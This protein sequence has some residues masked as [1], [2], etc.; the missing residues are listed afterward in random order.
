MIKPKYDWKYSGVDSD[1]KYD[2][3][4]HESELIQRILYN[5]GIIGKENID[6]FMNPKKE[7]IHDPF[8]LN[9]MNTAV[10]RI[11]IAIDKSEKITI[12]G[13]Y[14]VDGITSTST[15]YK[16]LKK[17]GANVSYYIPN[18]M[19]EGY[20]INKNALEIIKKDGTSLMITVDTGI[21]AVS[22]IEYAN[23]LGLD[24][25]I[26]DHHECQ[27]VIPD[28]YAVINPKR[29]DSTYPFSMLAGVGVAFKLVHALAIRL[30]NT[31]EIWEYLDLVAIGT[32]ADIVPLVGENRIIAKFGFETISNTQN[33]GV[34]AVLTELGYKNNRITSGFIGFSIAPRLNAAGRIDDAKKCVELFITEDIEVATK[35]AKEL[36][37]NNQDRQKIEQKIFKEAIEMIEGTKEIQEANVIVLANE[38]WHHGV[39]GIVASKIVERFY[40]PT[41]LMNIE[42]GEARGSARSIS[43][44]SIFEALGKAKDYLNKFGGHEMAAGLSLEVYN[45]E[46]LRLSLVEYCEEN[47]SQDMLIPK[48]KIERK[49]GC[50]DIT[51][52][53][54]EKIDMLQPYGIGNPEPI[55]EISGE[56]IDFRLLGK[57]S[58]H[59]KLKLEQKGDI[60]DTIMF[61]SSEY[62]EKLSE[63]MEL[64]IIGTVQ[65]N[66]WNGNIYPQM[67]IKDIRDKYYNKYVQFT[68]GNCME[69]VDCDVVVTR[70]DIAGV[71]KFLKRNSGSKIKVSEIN[72]ILKTNIFKIL[73]TFDVLN[74]SNLA[75]IT[76]VD[77]II[78]FD[79]KV[80]EKVDLSKSDILKKLNALIG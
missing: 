51:P 36:E 45:V 44:F 78:E 70:E 10:N 65:N 28:A 49:I 14:D 55:F 64:D 11:I 20:G 41:I 33:I 69:M 24:V 32:I 30:S 71:Y 50:G 75:N 5:R 25:I 29:P 52:N 7:H 80:S 6:K 43:G 13:D 12:Y 37:K 40:K 18:R 56:M 61:N 73:V 8:L 58:K 38:N 57:E 2:N 74:E 79:L 23:E 63:D 67:L 62:F 72:K 1:F 17:I 15:L 4:I 77:D 59:L 68:M 53:F 60:I 39:I 22:E 46:K 31:D 66:E 42:D 47:I 48:V 54:I 9:D 3:S 34:K 16:Y 21:A 27:E 26:T 19:D 76:L 35:I